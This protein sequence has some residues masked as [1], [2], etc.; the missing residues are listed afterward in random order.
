MAECSHSV[1]ILATTSVIL[2][3]S[4]IFSALV[5]SSAK[6]RSEKVTYLT[7]WLY[8]INVKSIHSFILDGVLNSTNRRCVRHSFYLRAV[9]SGKYAKQ[10]CKYADKQNIEV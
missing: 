8:I 6:W 2:G 1:R 10:I 4:L 7:G 3:R 5:S 9:Y